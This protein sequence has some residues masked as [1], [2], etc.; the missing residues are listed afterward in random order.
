MADNMT[1]SEFKEQT[2]KL[3]TEICCD[4]KKIASHTI[5]ST[6]SVHC[7]NSH[8]NYEIVDLQ[9]SMLMGCGCWDGIIIEIRKV[10]DEDHKTGEM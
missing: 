10:E 4:G 2:D 5:K 1:V 6:V 9:P 7:L 8:D 3:A